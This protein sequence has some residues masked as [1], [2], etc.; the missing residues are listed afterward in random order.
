MDPAGASRERRDRFGKPPAVDGCG[1]TG[2]W[3][4]RRQKRRRR[5][6]GRR[7]GETGRGGGMAA[8]PRGGRHAATTA[9]VDARAE[10]GCGWLVIGA[11][12]CTAPLR[13]HP[14]TAA[15]RHPLSHAPLRRKHQRKRARWGGRRLAA[16]II[17]LSLVLSLCPDRQ[18]A[19]LKTIQTQAFCSSAQHRKNTH[20]FQKR[21]TPTSNE[22]RC[23]GGSGHF[24]WQVESNRSFLT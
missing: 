19:V 15:R 14:L 17:R 12:L 5:W 13:L 11:S 1:V 24:L 20:A 9:W 21:Q 7:A 2:Q 4:W 3:R 16:L 10:C 18:L 22:E 8:R 23:F 6:F